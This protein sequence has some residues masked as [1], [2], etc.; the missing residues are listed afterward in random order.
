MSSDSGRIVILEY[1]ETENCFNRIHSET[2][3]KSGIR[4]VIPGQYLAADPKGRAVMIASVEKNKLVYV[5]NRNADEALTISS[6]LEAHKHFVL[7]H[8]LVAVDV[9]Y[10]N[11]K[12][13]AL[14]VNYEELEANNTGIQVND[15][16]KEIVFY[17]LDL[18]LNHVVRKHT[19]PCA[20]TANMLF[21][22]PGGEEGPSGVLV[23]AEDGIAWHHEQ[24]SLLRVPIPRRSGPNEDPNRKRYIVSGVMHRMRG[25]FFF[26]LQTDDGDLFKVNF[27]CQ[28]RMAGEEIKAQDAVNM[29]IKFF[30]T[31]P[32]C[33]SLIILKSGFLYGATESGDHVLYQ[34]EKLGDDDKDAVFGSDEYL[35]EYDDPERGLPPVYFTPRGFENLD[36]MESPKSLN[37]MTGLKIA[38]LTDDDAPQIYTVCG[39]GSRS[40]FRTIR[41]GLDVTE[42]V[43]SDLPNYPTS[44]WTTRASTEEPYDSFILLSFSNATLV[45][46]VG[47]TVEEASDSKFVTDAPTLGVQAMESGV[48]QIYPRGVKM[49]RP[50]GTTV[51]WQTPQYRTIVAC[52]TN[53]RQ[54]IVALSDGELV[55]WV[56]DEDG[57]LNE[58][59]DRP[60]MDAGVTTLSLGDIP[61]GRTGSS[62]CA[63]GL[64]DCKVKILSLSEESILEQI[65]VQAL[66]A[67]PTAMRIMA[68]EDNSSGGQ[69]LYLH[70]GLK[71]GV[72]LRT[73]MDDVTGDLSDT[74]NRFLGAAPVK[75]S[76]VTVGGRKAVLA[77]ATRSWLG[78]ADVQTKGFKL[79]PLNYPSLEWGCN[80]NSEQCPE[81]MVG[82]SRRTLRYGSNLHFPLLFTDES[83]NLTEIDRF[84]EDYNYFQ[85]FLLI[86]TQILPFHDCAYVSQIVNVPDRIFEVEHVNDHLL[87]QSIILSHTPRGFVKHFE[88]PI[89]YVG[90]AD[91]DTTSKDAQNP[92][93]NGMKQHSNRI[94]ASSSSWSSA[95]EVVDPINEREV[96]QKLE[97][98]DNEA[99]VSITI[100]AFANQDN[101]SFLVVGTG[102]DMEVL[103]TRSKAG[104]IHLYAMQDEGRSLEFIHKT[105]VE[106]PPRALLA[107]QGRLLVGIGKALRIYDCGLRQL[108]RKAQLENAVPTGIIGLQTQGSRIIVS[109]ISESVTYFVYKYL[110]NTFIPFA[111]DSIKRWTTAATMVDYEQT[112]GGD[113]FGNVWLVRCSGESS[114]MADEDEVGAHFLNDK[115]YL[116]ASSN[117]LELM[118]HF[119]V[120]DIPTS[121][122]KTSLVAGGRQILVWGG[123]QGTIGALIP[124]VSRD[125]VDFF[126]KLEMEMRNA[127]PPLSG[128]DHLIY[129]G[130][131]VPAK[132]V[133]DGDLCERYCA[134]PRQLKSRIAQALDMGI[135]E[136]DRKINDMRTMVAY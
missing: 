12:F 69:T 6:P 41:H 34:F 90:G 53:E 7:V 96:I 15:L 47:E 57:D 38:N 5:L 68:M 42:I 66:T 2:Y 24:Q 10:E 61:E 71:S 18:G 58:F 126:Q 87:Q 79:A 19:E 111:D 103:P 85:L 60:K 51:D 122:T 3:G 93:E 120:N 80:F 82:I 75:L 44:V 130:Y 136:V 36:P 119:Y 104:F 83:V 29:K 13:A 32:L 102:Q 128:R 108:L 81:G 97:M 14:E 30:D 70:I 49:I 101:Q 39:S 20:R 76:N 67:Q 50:D 4:R 121:I 118:V 99:I 94:K 112:A 73:V 65:S 72:Y 56:L 40:T 88:Y 17:E 63:V 113:R 23:C 95:I 123:L 8:A 129:R 91:K 16:V 33:T 117:R 106:E 133:I 25:D 27:E 48:L 43:S 92:G 55:Y 124:F 116:L 35:N 62:F 132:G 131:Y 98:E 86:F 127:D 77:M 22:V 89:F 11:P 125:D 105:Q 64:D 78:Y 26:L 109:D 37:A 134:L 46:S 107:F 114:R 84:D 54:V 115:G 74:L 9:G 28:P 45:L 135:R 110:T 100:A 52:S 31:I 1:M 59:Q 21:Q